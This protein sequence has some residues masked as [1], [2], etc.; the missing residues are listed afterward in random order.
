MTFAFGSFTLGAAMLFSAFKNQSLVS[1]ILGKGGESLSAQH[2]ANQSALAD[3]QAA[4]EANPKASSIP[5]ATV[6]AVDTYGGFKIPAGTPKHKAVA[7]AKGAAKIVWM[8]GRFPYSWDGGHSGFCTP[9]GVGENG[10]P[11]FDCSGTWSCVL[12]VMGIIS[13]PMS[14]GQMASTFISGPGKYITLWANEVHVFGKFLGVPFATGSDKEAKRGG[15]AIGNTDSTSGFKEC[16][17][18]G[19]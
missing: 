1:L 15:P 18:K 17:P 4:N 13:S 8:S 6:G 14:S 16:H 11:G 12:G 2:E 5:G 3:T 7:L 10:G 19:W 9:G